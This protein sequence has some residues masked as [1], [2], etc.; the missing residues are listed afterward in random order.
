MDDPAR[1]VC[2]GRPGHRRAAGGGGPA[3]ARHGGEPRQRD[4][5]GA[6]VAGPAGQRAAGRARHPRAGLVLGPEA[7]LTALAYR[8]AGRARRSAWG[9]AGRSW[10]S[11]GVR[12]HQHGVRGR[13]RALLLFELGAQR[14]VP[15]AALAR[16]CCPVPGV[17]TAALCSPARPLAGVP[18][19]PPLPPLPTTRPS[20]SD[21]AW[22]CW[23]PGAAWWRRRPPASRRWP[24]HARSPRGLLCRPV[25]RRPLASVPAVTSHR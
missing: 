4:R 17:G 12:G 14:L 13:C 15:S 21:V 8:R 7:P 1:L 23:C 19:G 2:A 5:A 16:R 25:C 24:Q 22:A 18:N 3:A 9:L 11:R 10:S 20:G 6:A